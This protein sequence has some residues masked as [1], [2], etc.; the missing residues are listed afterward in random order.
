MPDYGPAT[1]LHA[2]R[3]CNSRRVNGERDA[4]PEQIPIGRFVSQA[5]KPFWRAAVDSKVEMIGPQMSA[6]TVR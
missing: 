1:D 2:N 6:S 5:A 3:Q 4:A